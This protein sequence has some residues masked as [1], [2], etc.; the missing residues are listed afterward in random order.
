MDLANSRFSFSSKCLSGKLGKTGF[1]STETVI[2]QGFGS[3]WLHF[4]T[5][6]EAATGGVL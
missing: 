1:G 5:N 6:A 2:L 3:S 4:L